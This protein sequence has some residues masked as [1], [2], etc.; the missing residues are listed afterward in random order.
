MLNIFRQND[1]SVVSLFWKSGIEGD[2]VVPGPKSK[3]KQERDLVGINSKNDRLLFLAST[4]DFEETMDLPGH[5]LRSNGRIVIH[6]GLVDSHIYLIKK[7][8][9]DFLA[10]VSNSTYHQLRIA[11]N[12]T[13]F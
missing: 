1:A 3:Y 7:W 5:L 6:S 13:I 11:V 10:E 12:T 9:V 8:V 2:V 4:S